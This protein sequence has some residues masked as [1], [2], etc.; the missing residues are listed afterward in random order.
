ME[1]LIKWLDAGAEANYEQGVA[2][3]RKHSKNRNLV[4]HLA[5]KESSTNREKLTYELIKCG[6]EGD[7]EDVSAIENVLRSAA[8][9]V[10]QKPVYHL[11]TNTLIVPVAPPE[12][13]P[14]DVPEH[15]REQADDITVLMQ[16]LH[17]KR[18]QL[19]NTLADLSVPAEQQARV[20][21]ILELQKQYNALAEKRRLVLAGQQQP[22][23]QPTPAESPVAAEGEAPAVAPIVVD[24]AELINQLG[25][26][27]SNLSKAKGKLAKAPNEV[28][29]QEKVEKLY[30]EKHH[31]ETLIKAA[32]A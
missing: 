16:S 12:P 11:P 26:V 13:D 30:V 24:R 20:A 28:K 4:N 29:L 8:Q 19:S 15:L 22:V 9:H 32:V 25:N 14:V 27:R 21:E 6:C 10:E 7:I 2:L 31:L 18:C 3:L 5:R 1:D 17:N 23:E